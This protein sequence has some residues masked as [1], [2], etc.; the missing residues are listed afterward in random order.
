[1]KLLKIFFVSFLLAT[2][3]SACEVQDVW[4]VNDTVDGTPSNADTV[5]AHK[6]KNNQISDSTKEAREK[7]LSPEF[8]R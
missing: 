1:M 5:L 8:K 2:V 7:N 3:F 6:F 4:T